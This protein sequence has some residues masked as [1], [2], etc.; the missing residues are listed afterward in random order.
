MK[1]VS[2]ILLFVFSF[3]FA[4][5]EEIIRSG[6]SNL[7]YKTFGAGKPILIINGGPGMNCDGFSYLAKELAKQNFQTIIY[8]Q[9]GTGKSDVEKVNNETITMDVMVEDMEN[10]RKHLKIDKWILLGHSFGGIMASY[11][12]TKHPE[13]IE[14]LIFSS[15]GGLNMKFTS[16]VQQRLNNNLT[17]V[18][19]DS[20]S[21]YQKK[22]DSGDSSKETLQLRAK[23]LANAYVFDKS[24]API[25]AERL[26]QTKFEINS[27]VFESL[28]K[29]KF[30]CTN[31]F[32][33][34]KQPVL[35]LQG[36]NDIITTETATEISNAF[37]NSKLILMNNCGHY[38][39]LD[40][41][42][43]YFNSINNFL[44]SE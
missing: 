11:Y 7:H 34:F 25:I 35:V 15:S 1:L 37:P 27:L 26:T 4:Q 33:N 28:R 17:K 24:K 6:N 8:D 43:I 13:R 2:F 5:T 32:K 36:K 41:N 12:A 38:G 42:E 22:L 18:Q 44:K 29:I 14:K 40:A 16:Y 23:Y 30:D 9:R 3:S 20:L 31:S 19:R 39:W 21:Y 10:L